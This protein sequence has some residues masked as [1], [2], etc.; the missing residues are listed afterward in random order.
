MGAVVAERRRAGEELEDEGVRGEV[1]S[2]RACERVS[3]RV[4]F[5]LTEGRCEDVRA[6]VVREREGEA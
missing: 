4:I 5:C 1:S 6:I 3:R 2:R